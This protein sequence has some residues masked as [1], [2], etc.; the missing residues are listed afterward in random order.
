VKLSDVKGE[1]SLD[2]IADLIEPVVSLATSDEFKA[3]FKGSDGTDNAE[4]LRKY[5]PL[6][7]KAHKREIVTILSTIEGVSP[8]EY[9]E[10][11]TIASVI[12]DIAELMSDD[13]FTG[14]L[15]SVS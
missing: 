7:I 14:F 6:I 10:N 2:V 15:A 9:E 11:M 1:R 13:A 12:S 3:A 8:E 4:R 5:S